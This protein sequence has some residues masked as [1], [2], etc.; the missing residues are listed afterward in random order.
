MKLTHTL[1]LGLSTASLLAQTEP[2]GSFAA[3]PH[4]LSVTSAA[5]SPLELAWKPTGDVPPGYQPILG[6]PVGTAP[7]LRI[8]SMFPAALATHIRF[9]GIASGNDNIPYPSPPNGTDPGG[10]LNP[11]PVP[12]GTAGWMAIT[13]S[14]KQGS[15]GGSNGPIISQRAGQTGGNGADI[16]G[17]F[18]PGANTSSGTPGIASVP[19]AIIGRVYLE[20]GREHLNLTGFN[21][22]AHDA[23][24]PY[25]QAG[26]P[27][28]STLLL[29]NSAFFFSL[30]PASASAINTQVPQLWIP[31][32]PAHGADIY[33]ITWSTATKKW[34]APSVFRSR[35]QM[36]LGDSENIDAL[37]VKALTGTAPGDGVILFSTET[38]T[39]SDLL[40]QGSVPQLPTLGVMPVEPR[41]RNGV[42]IRL[43]S[44]GGVDAVTVYDPES[45]M[46]NPRMG[47]PIVS[48]LPWPTL[49]ASV[50]S[51]GSDFADPAGYL[52]S[53]SGFQRFETGIVTLMTR[54]NGGPAF[55]FT[56]F[57]TTGSSTIERQILGVP[58]GFEFDVWAQFQ[59]SGAPAPTKYS[60]VERI[61]P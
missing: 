50:A 2:R 25:V 34:S 55:A 20:Q 40:V 61:K 59:P 38:L 28:P 49:G 18:V 5:S 11:D 26:D 6:I 39:R 57:S 16:Y 46:A 52:V 58:S 12:G 41:D 32:T 22:D 23:Y 27:A 44:E 21:I 7:D 36:G 54:I 53:V 15:L 4:F 14:V 47:F 35:Q 24:L 10:I 30:T 37:A 42:P 48:A 17:Y 60:W 33:R 56:S 19:P 31:G 43:V 29:S 51:F 13:F 1:C 9:D 45:L 3:I 8:T